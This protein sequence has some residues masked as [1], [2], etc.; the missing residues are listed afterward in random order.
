MAEVVQEGSMPP[1]YYIPLHPSAS[2]TN[3]E[4]QVLVQQMQQFA[5]QRGGEGGGRG[6]EGERD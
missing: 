5:A 1:F 2:L 4:E 6:G 3:A